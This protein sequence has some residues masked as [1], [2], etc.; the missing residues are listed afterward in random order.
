[1]DL[2][3]RFEYWRQIRTPRNS[4]GL[5]WFLASELGQRFHASHGLLPWV[6][7]QHGLGYYDI[8]VN[9]LPSAINP[10]ESE[11]LGRFTRGGVSRTGAVGAPAITAPN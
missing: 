6:I 4:W 3:S 11:P 5:A 1:M 8:G 2:T 10:T 7:A 9:R